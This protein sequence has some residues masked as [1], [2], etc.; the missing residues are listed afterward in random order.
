MRNWDPFSIFKY[1]TGIFPMHAAFMIFFNSRKIW[2]D[3]SLNAKFPDQDV[4]D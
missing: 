3:K 2:E 4:M 1:L